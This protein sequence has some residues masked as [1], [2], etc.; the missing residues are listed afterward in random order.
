MLTEKFLKP[1]VIELQVMLSDFIEE[2]KKDYG[3]LKKNQ[4]RSFKNI[5]V[6]FCRSFQNMI[7][8]IF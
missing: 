4:K 6:R 3:L 1:G 7:G 8:M 5:K 2:V